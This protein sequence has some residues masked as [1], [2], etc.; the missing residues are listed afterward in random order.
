MLTCIICHFETELDDAVTPGAAG[1]C[2]C[3]R[4][5][6]RETGSA[7]RMPK[8]LRL[9]VMQTLESLEAA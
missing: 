4:C 3:L 7:L 9:A 6:E 2:V 5:Y 8:A 1:R